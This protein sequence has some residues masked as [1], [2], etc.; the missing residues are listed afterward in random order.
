MFYTD[1]CCKD[2]RILSEAFPSL[3]NGVQDH[4]RKDLAFEG[5]IVVAKDLD[6][7]NYLVSI[8]ETSETNT[9]GFDIEWNVTFVEG[10]PQP[11]AAILQ[12][13]TDEP[14]L[15]GKGLCVVFQLCHLSLFPDSLKQWLEND[16]Y[17]KVGVCTKADATK[18]FKDYGCQVNGVHDVAAFYRT[19][20][21]KYNMKFL[22]SKVLGCN[23]SKSP[24][25]RIS[26]W[27]ADELSETQKSYAANDAYAS[28]L[29]Y[30]RSITPVALD[31]IDNSL[32]AILCC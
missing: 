5:K 30:Q 15:D 19:K 17:S 29:L 12:V 11:K 24:G 27:E 16:Q 8:F 10:A 9:F 2:R 32:N 31:D 21:T 1:N 13:C 20:F 6:D 25:D 28:L 22:V 4:H 14:I 3:T 26:D 18:L 7:V 23:M